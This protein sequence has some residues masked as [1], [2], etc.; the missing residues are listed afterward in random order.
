L[1][2]QF[3]D[4]S[5]FQQDTSGPILGALSLYRWSGGTYDATVERNRVIAL[6]MKPNSTQDDLSCNQDEEQWTLNP[7]THVQSRRNLHGVE[8]NLMN[9]PAFSFDLV[10][11]DDSVQ[12]IGTCWEYYWT[13][14]SPHQILAGTKR[15]GKTAADFWMNKRWTKLLNRREIPHVL[16]RAATV[17]RTTRRRHG[18]YRWTITN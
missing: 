2:Q 10:E 11:Q 12:I 18:S 4:L 1:F 17:P 13:T 9:E 8:Q 7:G 16:N 3:L 15:F 6:K 5:S 14:W